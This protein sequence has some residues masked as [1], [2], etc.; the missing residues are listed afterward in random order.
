MSNLVM[1]RRQRP[2]SPLPPLPQPSC[3]L[4]V[5]WR[6][7]PPTVPLPSPSASPG[8]LVYGHTT[9]GYDMNLIEIAALGVVPPLS[10]AA[11]S[12]ISDATVSTNGGQKVRLY[13]TQCI[14]LLGLESHLP[15]KTVNLTFE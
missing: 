11:T 13:L 8:Q 12:P 5:A 7:I 4:P 10:D 15:H 2:G 9:E 6:P 3:R 14:Y 1:H